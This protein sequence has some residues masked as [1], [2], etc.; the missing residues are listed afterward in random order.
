MVD[1]PFQ[2]AVMADPVMSCLSSIS[3]SLAS[4]ERLNVHLGWDP[5]SNKDVGWL[6]VLGEIGEGNMTAM[7]KTGLV[8]RE[9]NMEMG[10]YTGKGRLEKL[11]KLL[12]AV[13]ETMPNRY[14]ARQYP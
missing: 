5:V 4:V 7:A 8:F 2:R 9:W 11:E 14:S 3:P 12:H 6:T 10:P 1:E 13:L